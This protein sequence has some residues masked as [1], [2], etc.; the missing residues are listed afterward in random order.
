M[1]VDALSQRYEEEHENTKPGK[2]ETN[3]SSVSPFPFFVFS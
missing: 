3:P 2:L 1:K